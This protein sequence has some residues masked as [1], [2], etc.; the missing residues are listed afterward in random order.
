MAMAFLGDRVPGATARLRVASET[1]QPPLR[2]SGGWQLLGSWRQHTEPAAQGLW[3][4]AQIARDLVGCQT[5]IGN[6][7]DGFELKVP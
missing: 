3:L 5:S 2:Q 6:Q 4:N 7:L 1:A